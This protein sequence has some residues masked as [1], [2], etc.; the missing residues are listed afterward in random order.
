MDR[1][2]ITVRFTRIDGGRA[3]IA[4]DLSDDT[5]GVGASLTEALTEMRCAQRARAMGIGDER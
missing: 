1:D 4:R 3:W 5:E 2:T